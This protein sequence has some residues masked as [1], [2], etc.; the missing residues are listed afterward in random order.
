MWEPQES[1]HCSKILNLNPK[2]QNDTTLQRAT[3]TG[4]CEKKYFSL[5]ESF[6]CIKAEQSGLDSP[7]NLNILISEL[8]EMAMLCKIQ[9]YKGKVKLIWQYFGKKCCDKFSMIIPVKSVYFSWRSYFHVNRFCFS[10]VC[11]LRKQ[12]KYLKTF[13]W[14][15]FL[16]VIPLCW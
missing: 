8:C 5:K 13:Q 6:G 12:K 16:P 10:I 7:L 3:A 11:S 15:N 2:T 9:N 1:L 4:C 14:S